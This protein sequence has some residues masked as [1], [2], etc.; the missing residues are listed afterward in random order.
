MRDMLFFGLIFAVFLFGFGVM[1]HANMYPNAKLDYKLLIEIIHMPYW[2]LYG[3]LFLDV[4][5]G[6]I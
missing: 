4:F 6:K 2:Q 1:F 3:E 5:E